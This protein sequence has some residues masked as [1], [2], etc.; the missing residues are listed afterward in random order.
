MAEHRILYLP[1]FEPGTVHDL[2]VVNKRGLYDGLS[3]YAKVAELDYLNIPRPEL[4]G[5]VVQVLREID[6]T[7]LFTQL[8]AADCLTP[9]NM[10]DIRALFPNLIIINWSGDHWHHSLTSPSM[11][12]LCH[13]LDFQLTAAIDAIVTYAENEIKAFYWNM[14][15]EKPV[16]D[17]P[18]MPTYDI[19]FLANVVSERRRELMKF[20]KSLPYNV[21]IYG[22]WD[23]RDGRNVYDFGQ[24]EALYK[25]ATISIADN[26]YPESCNFMSNRVYQTLVAGGAILLQQHIPRMAE[27][28]GLVDGVHYIEWQENDDLKDKIA[29]WLDPEHAPE[30]CQIVEQGREFA[31][32]KHTYAERARQLFKE[33]LPEVIRA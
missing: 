19:V 31:L 23:G 2:Q 9:Q 6:A 5:A 1:I 4:F 27:I 13:T 21:G 11:L 16:G 3:L 30:R 32:A 25:N 17:L 29:Y 8:H 7:I 18:D 33:F 15:Y 26:T 24:G 28:G 20:L 12:E 22:D 10:R 14:G